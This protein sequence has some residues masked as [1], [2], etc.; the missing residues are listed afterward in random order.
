[1]DVLELGLLGLE[2][3]LEFCLVG[4]EL[5]LELGN[6]VLELEKDVP[7]RLGV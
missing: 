7:F 6:V 2:V 4:I 3:G 1:M 5:Y